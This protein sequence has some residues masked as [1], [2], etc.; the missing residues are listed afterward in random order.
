MNK[1]SVIITSYH[2]RDF[3]V[4]CIKS[5]LKFCPDDLELKLIVV[6]NSGDI[7]YKDE[8]LSLGKNITWVQNDT[9]MRG[10]DANAEGVEVGM[11]YV[12]DEYV[13]LSHNDVSILPNF[14]SSM[15]EKVAEGNRLIGTC[16]DINPSRNHSIIILG[17]L[18]DP[19]IVR[20]VDLYPTPYIPGSPF[21]TCFECGDRIHLYCKEND[22][23]HYCF[24]STHNYP[25][26]IETLS[27]PFKDIPFT[28][29]TVDDNNDVIFIHWARG[30]T[31]TSGDY[32]RQ[33]SG[34][35]SV[36]QIMNFCE[37]QI[38]SK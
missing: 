7:S 37:N 13:F 1:M 30:T 12:G 29:R 23:K 10:A 2:Q 36:S 27:D 9:K 5:Y 31:K 18:V 15:R 38:H 4:N 25:E 19:K 28:L 33:F 22:I 17:C 32:Y 11:R 35:W 34:R 16:S 14:Y 6:E 8:V 21:G 24:K 20:A 26:I 3:T